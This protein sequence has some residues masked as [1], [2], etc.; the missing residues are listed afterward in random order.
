[1]AD[2]LK[3]KGENNICKNVL[4]AGRET[5]AGEDL[6]NEY[7]ER[8]KK[9]NIRCDT[10]GT[11]PIPAKARSNEF[12]L[13]K[14][15]WPENNKEIRT[16]LNK[17]KRVKDIEMPTEKTERNYLQDMTLADARLWFIYRCQILDDIKG[18]RSSQWENRMHCRH[19]ITGENE[20]Q[21]HLEKCTF[22][23]KYRESLDLTIREHQLKFWRRVTH[24]LKDTKIANKDMIDNNTSVIVPELKNNDTT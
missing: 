15:L 16:D 21:E 1:M 6:L 5:C 19:C 22:F 14:A 2:N 12:N 3:E 9:L 7:I 11:D 10:M 20:T 4:I 8:C 24:I 18:N 13:K 23:R 17:P